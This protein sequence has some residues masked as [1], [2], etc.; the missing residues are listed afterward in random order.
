MPNLADRKARF[1]DLFNVFLNVGKHPQLFQLID[2]KE[3]ITTF[4]ENNGYDNPDKF[5]APETPFVQM[6]NAL[7]EMP[8][9]VQQQAL[10][11]MQNLTQSAVK[12]TQDLQMQQQAM[13]QQAMQQQGMA[14][15]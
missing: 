3:V 10:P 5:F 11:I 2:W 14:G 1:Q 9:P 7:N 12:M 6:A 15:V 4:I 13:Q 8:Q